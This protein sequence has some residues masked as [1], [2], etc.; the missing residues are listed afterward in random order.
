M[1][2][3]GL[4]VRWNALHEQHRENAERFGNRER[5]HDLKRH[6]ANQMPRAGFEKGARS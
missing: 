6:R 5:S 1:G 4:R 2:M 3:K